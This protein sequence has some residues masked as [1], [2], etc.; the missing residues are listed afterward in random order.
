MKQPQLVSEE[1]ILTNILSWEGEVVDNAA[2]DV[3]VRRLYA[4]GLFLEVRAKC[5]QNQ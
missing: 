4:S 2:L 1:Q 5:E 3:D